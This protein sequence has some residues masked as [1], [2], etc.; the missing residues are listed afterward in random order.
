MARINRHRLSSQKPVLSRFSLT[1][2]VALV[3]GACGQ[4]GR[5]F[6]QALAEAGARVVLCDIAKRPV[7]ALA[8]HYAEV[9]RSPMLGL[10]MDVTRPVSI[11]AGLR[12]VKRWAGSLDIL[13]NNAGMGLFTPWESR[14]EKEANRIIDLN[15]KGVL[16]CTKIFSRFMRQ[17]RRGS[18]INIGS[19]YGLVSADPRIY[20]K[21]GRNSAELYAATKGGVIQMT[22]YM[23]VHLAPY[24]IRVNSITPGGVFQHQEK[25]FV[26][27]YADKTPL[28]RM[29]QEDELNG[30]VVFLASE[31]SSYVTGHNLV[32]DGGFTAW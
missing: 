9:Y 19:I 12:Q 8:K 27:K 23:A 6:V 26:K 2:R 4:L 30:A 20:G 22:R 14:T 32:V 3:T 25:A 5:Q 10:S 15:I 17:C 29:A 21:S 24:N 1:D 7:L 11:E 18:I 13:V 16:W 28:H 31:A